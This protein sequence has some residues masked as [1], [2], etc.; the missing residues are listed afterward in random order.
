MA[1]S[2]VAA[3]HRERKS[4]DA[5][6]RTVIISNLMRLSGEAEDG[7]SKRFGEVGAKLIARL[8]SNDAAVFA[9]FKAASSISFVS[10]R[11]APCL[12]PSTHND[13]GLEHPDF[14]RFQDLV[15]R[16]LPLAELLRD[17]ERGYVLWNAEQ[18]VPQP[19]RND[20][21]AE[22][23]EER[24]RSLDALVALLTEC[25]PPPPARKKDPR[26]HWHAAARYFASCIEDAFQ[27][28]GIESP[29]RSSALSPLVLA[30]HDL[31]EV[32]GFTQ[33]PDAIRKVLGKI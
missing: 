32:V 16:L 24:L 9:C 5:A 13:W 19:C 26:S 8:G 20:F 7:Y 30:V 27:S 1:L 22:F 3:P 29:S 21:I 15:R 18:S 11:R 14:R 12:N 4:V 31:L 10:D 28:A 6:S 25:C 33:E 23:I 2:D 17:W